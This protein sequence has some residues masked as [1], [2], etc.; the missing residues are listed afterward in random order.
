MGLIRFLI[1][2]VFLLCRIAALATDP[3][4][5]DG[6]ATVYDELLSEREKELSNDKTT[7]EKLRSDFTASLSSGNEDSLIVIYLESELHD[8]TVSPGV[9][10]SIYLQ[11]GDFFSQRKAYPQALNCRLKELA[12]YDH[13]SNAE[14]LLDHFFSY[15]GVAGLY[16]QVKQPKKA[17]EY[18][19]QALNF[20]RKC[21]DPFMNL[22]AFNNLGIYN[23]R[24]GRNQEALKYFE[25]ALTTKGLPDSRP[26]RLMRGIIEGN[27]ATALKNLG[28]NKESLVHFEANLNTSKEE[29]EIYDYI[30]TIPVYAT[31]LKT[32]GEYKEAIRLLKEG[33]QLAE[34][35]NFPALQVEIYQALF[36]TYMNTGEVALA[37]TYWD[38]YH[39]AF[40][41]QMAVERA[42]YTEAMESLAGQQLARLEADKINKDLAVRLANSRMQR[43]LFLGGAI[44]LV[45]VIVI[46][47]IQKRN[48][49]ISKQALFEKMQNDLLAVELK[50][51]E[52]LQQRTDLELRSSKMDLTSM[53]IDLNQHESIRKSLVKSLKEVRKVAEDS[54]AGEMVAKI[55][56]NVNKEMNSGQSRALFN[57]NISKVNNAF[58]TKLKAEYPELSKSELE[59]CGLLRLNL[60]SKEISNI[61]NITP[62]SAKV[63]R[64]RIRK[65]LGLTAEDDIYEALQLV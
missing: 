39:D 35:N 51:K 36:E 16:Q 13:L 30:H 19:Q 27:L 45:A 7:L 54:E 17:L 44:L 65:K 38:K 55:I 10:I 47:I 42:Q 4:A 24:A 15:G 48:R 50:N 6:A 33:Q 37:K 41:K 1:V 61:K 57:E 12:L 40:Q 43:F 26:V 32:E 2:F 56:S 18:Y 25:L 34:S 22:H 28:R 3:G 14:M 52:L 31:S 9:G 53:A 29:N 59:F 21:K 8:F 20:A 58:F 11:M 60:N 63:M 49:E 5:A 46:L 23:L 64:H 62:D